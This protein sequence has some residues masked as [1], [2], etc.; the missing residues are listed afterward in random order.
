MLQPCKGKANYVFACLTGR[1]QSHLHSKPPQQAVLL[2]HH[3]LIQ[4]RLKHVRGEF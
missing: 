3:L 1:W 4:S 2:R